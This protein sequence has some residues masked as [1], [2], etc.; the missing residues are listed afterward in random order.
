[1]ATA[2]AQF[3]AENVGGHA[4]TL[5]KEQRFPTGDGSVAATTLTRVLSVV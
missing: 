5:L 3:S 4:E 2:A 1:M